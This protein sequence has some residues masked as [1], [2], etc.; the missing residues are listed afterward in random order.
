M[1][2]SHCY[3]TDRSTW[4]EFEGLFY[5]QTVL[6]NGCVSIPVPDGQL[7]SITCYFYA[8]ILLEYSEN[9]QTYNEA[10]K[11]VHL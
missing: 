4:V 2:I 1:N 11:V 5:I 7:Q 6:G 10:N 3:S 9:S 8:L